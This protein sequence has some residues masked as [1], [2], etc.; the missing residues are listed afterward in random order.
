MTPTQFEVIKLVLESIGYLLAA[1]ITICCT[2]LHL[3]LHHTID[4]ACKKLGESIEEKY[5]SRELAMATFVHR[6]PR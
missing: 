2:Y 1:L 4:R 5:M 6:G 3:V